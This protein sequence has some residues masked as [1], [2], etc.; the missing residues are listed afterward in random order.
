MYTLEKNIQQLYQTIAKFLNNRISL[1]L[2]F[3]CMSQYHSIILFNSSFITLIHI[4][5]SSPK[6]LTNSYKSV[7]NC[8]KRLH[9]MKNCFSGDSLPSLC[10]NTILR[11]ILAIMEEIK[12]K[13]GLIVPDRCCHIMLYTFFYNMSACLF[14]CLFVS[15]WH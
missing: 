6:I 4:R 9:Q 1:V 5:E 13:I 3:F 8:N 7:S 10:R 12:A 14:V 2:V 11:A 15:A